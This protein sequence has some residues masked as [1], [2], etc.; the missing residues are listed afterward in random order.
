MRVLKCLMIFSLVFLVGCSN[1]E[2]E[3]V[4]TNEQIVTEYGTYKLDNT[5][6]EM[7]IKEIKDL[8][9]VEPSAPSGGYNF[10]EDKKG[11]HYNV[12]IGTFKN[13]SQ[14][15]LNGKNFITKAKRDKKI[16]DSKFAIENADGST[17]MFDQDTAGSEIN[18]YIVSIVKD[19]KEPPSTFELYYQNDLKPNTDSKSWDNKLVINISQ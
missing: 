5:K 1:K 14:E 3:I 11:T 18:F 7:E 13:P 17:L 10:Y 12:V 9:E 6:L 19:G 16:Y 8:E 2:D 4:A 15:I